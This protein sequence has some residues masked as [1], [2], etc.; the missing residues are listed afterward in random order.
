[1]RGVRVLEFSG[2]L[3]IFV[4]ARIEEELSVIEW[5][6]FDSWSIVDL[7]RVRYLDTTFINALM[8]LRDR[9][10]RS[11]STTRVCLVVPGTGIVRRIF[12]IM[13]LDEYFPLFDDVPSARRSGMTLLT[14]PDAASL[15]E[16]LGPAASANDGNA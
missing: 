10:L 6:E 15:A 1:M 11:G 2:E 3:D 5:D 13:E 7:T 9:L 16:D 12:E 8:S 14:N 4:K